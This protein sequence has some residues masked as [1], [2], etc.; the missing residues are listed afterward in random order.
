VLRSSS[1]NSDA[2]GEALLLPNP[3]AVPNGY[4]NP[5]H[6][7]TVPTNHAPGPQ[8]QQQQYAGPKGAV[9]PSQQQQ[10][11]QQGRKQRT[12]LQ[13]LRRWF[14]IT[15]ASAGLMALGAWGGSLAYRC[16]F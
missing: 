14:V 16:V 6:Y 15:S 2:D 9:V 12:F 3:F 8:Q 10:R 5:Q 13:R 1:I 4:I 7:L 11:Q